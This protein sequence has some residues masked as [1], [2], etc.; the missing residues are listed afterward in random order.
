MLRAVAMLSGC[1]AA[2]VDDVEFAEFAEF[3]HSGVRGFVGHRDGQI[4]HIRTAE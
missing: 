2:D 4:L 1:G 3:P